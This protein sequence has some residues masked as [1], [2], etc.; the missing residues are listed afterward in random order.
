M[1][2]LECWILNAS[3]HYS[4]TPAFSRET[5]EHNE[6]Y[7]AFSALSSLLTVEY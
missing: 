5:M 2:V 6:A 3:L 1:G 4:S 7:E